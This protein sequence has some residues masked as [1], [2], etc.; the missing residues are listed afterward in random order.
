MSTIWYP[1]YVT[2]SLKIIKYSKIPPESGQKHEQNNSPASISVYGMSTFLQGK[3]R[4]TF[5][6]DYMALLEGS[7]SRLVGPENP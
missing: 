1:E 4:L 3:P 5:L 6:G 2:S 7:A